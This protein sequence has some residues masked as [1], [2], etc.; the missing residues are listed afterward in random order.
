MR[1]SFK[2]FVLPLVALA[3][4]AFAPAARAAA[5]AGPALYGISGSAAPKL[6]VIDPATGTSQGF[7]SLGLDAV[8]A[9]TT[10]LKSD[11]TVLYVAGNVGGSPTLK[12]IAPFGP[13]IGTATLDR[14]FANLAVRTDG[15][16]IGLAQN[17]GAWELRSI[18]PTTGVSTLIAVVTDLATLVPSARVL[19]GVGNLIQLGFTAAD[20]TVP[21]LFVINATTGLVSSSAASDRLYTSLAYRFGHLGTSWSG[22]AEELRSVNASTGASSLVNAYLPFGILPPA[23]NALDFAND[24]VYQVGYAASA[25]DP[26]HLYG[27]SGAVQTDVSLDAQY[28]ALVHASEAPVLALDEPVHHVL[29]LAPA[30]PNP[31]RASTRIPFSLERSARVRLQIVDISGRV[32]RRLVDRTMEAGDHAAVWRGLDEGG[33]T[34]P[35]GV[36]FTQMRV[37]DRELKG[38]VVVMR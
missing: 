9:A 33:R 15:T 32:V 23:A 2:C 8:V 34:V 6:R 11:G 30:A 24:I 10:A 29:A 35:V 36:Y 21:R 20:P 27:V 26:A 7:L 1:I 16:L 3:A 31:F 18:A 5:I 14:P 4:C 12:T 38:R 28:V 17:A 22:S 13:T 37:G 25:A 19:D